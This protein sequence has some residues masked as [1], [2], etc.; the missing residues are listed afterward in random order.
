[1]NADV[2]MLFTTHLEPASI[3]NQTIHVYECTGSGSSACSSKTEIGAAIQ[4]I[5]PADG[6]SGEGRDYVQVHPASLKPSTTYQVVLTTGVRGLGVGGTFME[7]DAKNCGAG[8]A[9]CFNFTTKNDATPCAVASVIVS[10]ITFTARAQSEKIPYTAVPRP[11][12]Q[13]LVMA[14]DPYDWHWD[15]SEPRASIT[16]DQLNGRGS[17]HQTATA[18]LETNPGSP[19][20]VRTTEAASA[21]VG[22][23]D[24]TISF[25][26]PEVV[27]YG[28]ACKAACVNAE[29][30]ATFNTEMDDATMAQN[31]EVKECAHEDCSTYTATLPITPSNI[32]LGTV[33][34]SSD[35]RVRQLKIIPKGGTPEINLLQPGHFYRVILHGGTL[36]GIRSTSLSPLSKLNSPDGFTWTFSTRSGDG[37]V[38]VAE[39]VDVSPNEKYATVVGDRQLFTA[40][41]FSKPDECSSNGQ[42][43]FIDSGYGWATSKPQVADFY[44]SGQLDTGSQ[45]PAG[46]SDRCT[47]LGSD[48]VNGKTARCG[49]EIVEN[50]DPSYCA[51]Y[52][53]SGGSTS[54]VTLAAGGSGGEECDGDAG[55]NA[56]CLWDP[57]APFTCSGNMTIPQ[58]MAQ[59]GMGSCGN[60]MGNPKEECDPGRTCTGTLP[61]SS[62][63]P[64]IDCTE[65]AK[66]AECVANHGTCAPMNRNGCSGGCQNLGA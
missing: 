35:P 24:L 65:P 23:G 25:L 36:N 2:G 13:C 6:A 7:E 52:Q 43:I 49:N 17:C 30:W 8:N 9:Y 4:A 20:Q 32:T 29:I 33:P 58:C 21:S 38:C 63:P 47:L 44:W 18:L 28:P 51:R 53:A 64:G 41:P 62:T 3:T 5:M 31:V 42:A 46:C 39:R 60:G 45:L 1:M 26:K 50:T 40:T 15:V 10:P 12:D 34:Y 61:D 57:V 54:C 66:A 22:S 48:G 59:P 16:N 19:V 11:T 37:A 27:A 55:C 14:C 56:S